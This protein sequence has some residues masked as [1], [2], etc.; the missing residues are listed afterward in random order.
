MKKMFIV[1]AIML[2][3][4]GAM[5]SCKDSVE[6]GCHCTVDVSYMGQTATQEMDFTAEQVKADGFSSCSALATKA[7]KDAK[8]NMPEGMAD[9]KYSVSCKGK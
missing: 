2:F 9:V 3:A 7:E 4:A 8:A 6:N 5:T 1:S